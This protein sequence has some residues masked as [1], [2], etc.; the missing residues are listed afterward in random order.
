M[1]NAIK[2]MQDAGVQACA[3][4][5]IGNEQERNRE[6]MSSNI[7]DRTLHELY[8]WP[9]A[10]SVK[11]GVASFMCSYNKLNGTWACE[12]D[13]MINGIL[14]GEL[15]FQGYMVS[16]ESR[17]RYVNFSECLAYIHYL[18]ERLERPTHHQRRRQRRHGYVYA[19]H[20]LQW[21]QP[22]LGPK[23]SQLNLQRSCAPVSPRRHG[24]PNLGS[25]VPTQTRRRI[26]CRHLVKLEWWYWSSECRGRPCK[27]RETDCTRRN[28]T[29]EEQQQGIASVEACEPGTYW[30]GSGRESGGS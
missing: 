8:L 5:F 9:F 7:D 6:T 22:A 25:L 29:A 4:H 27:A 24:D 16:V 11:A 19:R 20:R 23:P 21:Q 26:P 10:D 3:K 1:T 30:I 13:K 14:K 12:N 17:V 15:N 18:D 2:G 28:S